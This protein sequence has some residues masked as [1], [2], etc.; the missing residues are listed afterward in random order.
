MAKAS[1]DLHV[2]IVGAG[3]GGLA[4][5]LA[6]AKNGFTNIHVYETA[7]DLGFVGAGI[8]LA[9]NMARILDRLGCWSEIEREGTDI[10]ETSIRQGSTNIELAHVEMRYI[11][12]E[13]SHPHM[14]GHRASLSKSLYNACKSESARI[15]FHFRSRLTT[16]SSFGPQPTFTIEPRDGT[17]Y[18]VTCDVLLA[19]DG[20]KSVARDAMLKD[21]NVDASVM[22]VDTQQAA[23]RIMLDRRDMEHDPEL[24][25]L[26]NMNGNVRW[27]G[28][29]RHI[30]AYPV[31]N[32]TVYNLSTCQP[33]THF[34]AAT[35]ETYTT[36]GSKPEMLQTFE[37]FAPIV[38]KMLNM[39]PDGEVCEWKLRVHT[40][41]PTWIH[42]TT[43]LLGDSSHPTLP[44]LNQGAAQAI[45]DAATIAIC[46][47]KLPN[48]DPTSINKALRVFEQIRK[49]RAE[50]L[51]ELAAQSGRNLHLGEGRAREE[52]DEAF[53]AAGGGGKVPD[54][55][56]DRDVQKMIYGFDVWEETERRFDGIF[57]GL[58]A[59]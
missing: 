20:I 55:W 4:S 3:M 53:R 15:T 10:Q 42:T 13:Y 46:L 47:R 44:H 54:K 36:K 6:L 9:V 51:V 27:I 39:V 37:D 11:R 48:T 56:A 2:C 16:I 31:S 32:H 35:N 34:A 7:S 49:A 28:E 19:C 24:M 18:E 21:L 5:A 59:E 12:K 43:A 41:L 1:T 50:L 26:I 45:E 25:E 38:K 29:R 22:V 40:P 52:R 33:D 23:Y 14:T 30:I 58:S 57:E 17:P 8:Q